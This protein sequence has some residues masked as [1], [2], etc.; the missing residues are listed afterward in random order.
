MKDKLKLMKVAKGYPKV[1]TLI[2]YKHAT[3]TSPFPHL[4][5]TEELKW[6]QKKVASGVA[7]KLSVICPQNEKLIALKKPRITYLCG[8]SQL[9]CRRIQRSSPRQIRM[10]T[11]R[12]TRALS[13]VSAHHDGFPSTPRILEMVSEHLQADISINAY[14]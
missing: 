3:E 1:K 7:T 2:S 6:F 10:Q 4:Q 12:M 14:L 11:V 8:C 9:L 13:L 5:F